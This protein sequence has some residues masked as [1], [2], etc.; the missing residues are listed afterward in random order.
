MLEATGQRTIWPSKL[1]ETATAIKAAFHNTV[2][3]ILAR[4][5]AEDVGVSDD[6]P[7]QL[8][9]R[10][11]FRKSRVSDVSARI[12]ARMSVSMS[13]SWN[14]G[15]INKKH[16]KNVGPIRHCEP[17]HAACSNF[18]L[19]FTRYRYCRHHYQDKMSRSQL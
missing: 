6:F 2:T 14:A 18:I 13:M 4:I 8:A 19:P 11:N 5:V 17:L 12:L 15:F 9:D 1:D 16:L 10:N 3:D 7:V